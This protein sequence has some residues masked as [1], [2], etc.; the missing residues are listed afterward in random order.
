M[1]VLCR[2]LPG[3]LRTTTK[4]ISRCRGQ[5]S[6]KRF[7]NRSPDRH[8][9]TNILGFNNGAVLHIISSCNYVPNLGNNSSSKERPII[10]R[11][12]VWGEGGMTLIH[13]GRTTW[14]CAT[15]TC[16]PLTPCIPLAIDSSLPARHF[17]RHS[18][19]SCDTT[20][21]ELTLWPVQFR[22]RLDVGTDRTEKQNAI[23]H[24]TAL[25]ITITTNCSTFIFTFMISF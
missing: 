19:H 11:V 22:F 2:H 16:S 20:Q 1:K 18:F 15:D 4:N 21:T 7:P 25:T 8:D 12:R 14:A 9:Y 24:T 3:E 10:R 23:I 13:I 17:G 5:D 6:R